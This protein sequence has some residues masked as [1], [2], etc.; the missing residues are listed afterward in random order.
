MNWIEKEP[1]F[2]ELEVPTNSAIK[3]T[4]QK[5]PEQDHC[6]GNIYFRNRNVYTKIIKPK[7]DAE[8]TSS[9]LGLLGSQI[10]EALGI[11]KK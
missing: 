9:F 10:F 4:I 11:N 5:Y 6:V 2:W 1:G 7:E 8:S 3:I